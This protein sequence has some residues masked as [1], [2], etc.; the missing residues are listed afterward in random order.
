MGPRRGAGS[1]PGGLPLLASWL[2]GLLPPA[3]C[4]HLRLVPVPVGSFL[5]NYGW[6]ILGVVLLYFLVRRISQSLES[7]PDG[8][9]RAADAA[10][11][12]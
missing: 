2:G 12:E 10:M 8:Q 4:A 6:F 9:P 1:R 7:E 3:A 11:G 5:S